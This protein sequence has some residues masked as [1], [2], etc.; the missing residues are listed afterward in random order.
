MLH[1]SRIKLTEFGT[2]QS[3]RIGQR[4]REFALFATEIKR[5]RI[6]S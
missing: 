6:I 3:S 1:K 2:R 4:F 5:L